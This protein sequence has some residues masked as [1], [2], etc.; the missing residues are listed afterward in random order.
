MSQPP[1]SPGHDPQNPGPDPQ[2]PHDD[3]PWTEQPTPTAADGQPHVAPVGADGQPHPGAPGPDGQPVNGPVGPDGQ[4]WMGPIG[5]DGQPWMGP[6]GP[7]GQPWMEHDPS[8]V[9][10]QGNKFGIKQLLSALLVVAV[11][12]AGA[13]FLWNNYQSDAALAAGNCLVLSGEMDD[14]QHEA[15]DCDDQSVYSQYVGEVIDGDG[16]CTDETAAPYTIV[17][18]SG[19]GG[20]ETTTKVTC[21]VPQLF[22]N[23]CYNFSEGVNELEPADCATA[24]LKVT[25]VTDETGSECAAEEESLSYTKPARTYCVA[26]QE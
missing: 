13:W 26:F 4:P 6:L 14:A 5:P 7:D 24:E 2:S 25:R 1:N 9:A 12:G 21:L 16:T 10:P 8:Q 15:V 3:Q 19:R 22:E 17:Q 18:T 23:A 11:L 20:K